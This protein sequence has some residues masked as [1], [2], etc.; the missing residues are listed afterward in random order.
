MPVSFLHAGAPLLSTRGRGL[1]STA[2][3][4][5]APATPR[6]DYDS[7]GLTMGPMQKSDGHPETVLS[8]QVSWLLVEAFER[9]FLDVP[10]PLLAGL[11]AAQT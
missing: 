2:P 5:T 10:G 9:A 11:V 1:K 8:G 3:G 6:G 7:H 4:V